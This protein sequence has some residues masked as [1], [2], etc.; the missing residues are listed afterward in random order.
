MTN[1]YH[2]WYQRE[3]HEK[4]NR[5]H[6]QETNMKEHAYPYRARFVWGISEIEVIVSLEGVVPKCFVPSSNVIYALT[7]LPESHMAHE[8]LRGCVVKS[9]ILANAVAKLG[10]PD[11]L[12]MY[13]IRPLTPSPTLGNTGGTEH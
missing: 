3:K 11:V 12:R 5:E 1:P 4:W 8:I 13:D 7:A 10:V 9:E 2:Y 6:P